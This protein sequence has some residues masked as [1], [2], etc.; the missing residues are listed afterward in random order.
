MKIPVDRQLISSVKGFLDEEEGRCLYETAL[1]AGSREPCLEIGSYCG[2]SALYLGAACRKNAT[3]LFSVDHHRGSEEQQPGEEYFDPDLFDPF[4]GRV[5]TL[6]P[7]RDTLQ[8]A[9]LEDTVVP[10]VCRSEVAARMWATPLSLVFIDGG[11][12]F[13]TVLSDYTVWSP[14]IVAGGYLLIHDIFSDPAQGGQAPYKV[15]QRALA[16]GIFRKVKMVK[17]LA[18]LQRR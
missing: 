2:K 9:G 12:A 8:R 18:V 17:S 13:E 6:R 11:H 7:F 4:S 15:Y 3:V 14:H 1:A 10:I 5:D 16:S